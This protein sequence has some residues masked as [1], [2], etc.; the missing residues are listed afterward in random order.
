M[1]KYPRARPIFL[2]EFKVKFYIEDNFV[3]LHNGETIKESRY[4]SVHPER[5]LSYC[6]V[7]RKIRG[8]KERQKLSYPINVTRY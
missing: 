8:V 5:P 7:E 3:K 4:L 1:L 2:D 6:I